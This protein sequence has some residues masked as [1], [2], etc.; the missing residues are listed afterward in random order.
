MRYDSYAQEYEDIILYAI[1]GDVS[2][3]FYIDVGA[4]DPVDISVT[5]YFYDKGW[6]GINIEPLKKTMSYV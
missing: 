4:Y 3:G 1:I 5:K 6:H 2:D